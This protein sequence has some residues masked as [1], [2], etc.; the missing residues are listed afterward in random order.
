MLLNLPPRVVWET[1]AHSAPSNACRERP[2]ILS[3]TLWK[4]DLI[5][6]T[7]NIFS[8]HV[9]SSLCN[10]GLSAG[11]SFAFAIA[12]ALIIWLDSLCYGYDTKLMRLKV[13][14]LVVNFIMEINCQRQGTVRKIL[15]RHYDKC[16]LSLFFNRH[17]RWYTK[18]A[19]MYQPV[20]VPWS[21]S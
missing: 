6:T 9:S 12:S 2:G 16:L 10:T 14:K 3:P 18:Y 4:S 11:D 15:P 21:H 7:E 13:G 8:N 19:V 1:H 17:G 5:Y 20:Y